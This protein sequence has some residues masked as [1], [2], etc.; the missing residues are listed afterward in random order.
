MWSKK[1]FN[2]FAVMPYVLYID[3]DIL[4]ASLDH[5]VIARVDGRQLVRVASAAVAVV[6][7]VA[8]LP[9]GG[10]TATSVSPPAADAIDT[11]L[12]TDTDGDGLTDYQERAV[13]ETAPNQSDTDGDGIPDGAEV[14]CS[15]VYPDADPLRQDI[16]V[17]VDASD[18]LTLANDT[19]AEITRTFD[20]APVSNP[21]GPDGIDLH[22]V[23]N[24][25]DLAADGAVDSTVRDG[26]H[27]DIHDYYDDHFDRRDAGY[28][29]VVVTSE[30]AFE[31]DS[32]Y[33]GTGEPG[34]AAI[35]PLA[36]TELTA[37]LFMH[38]M[39]HSFGI[40]PDLDGVDANRYDADEYESVMNYN[41]LYERL[42]YSDGTDEVGRDEWAHV[43][44][45]RYQPSVDCPDDDCATGCPAV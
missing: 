43:G 14:R 37:S 32:Y 44:D 16:Y 34:M 11:P 39:G 31:G 10:V 19:V 26:D 28:Y 24:D 33:V 35:E 13:Y 12:T 40:G 45:D 27:N 5:S 4:E 22:I 41:A 23:P 17:E 9:A 29:Y 8:L 30:V 38:E 21:H 42:G 15:A 36:E 20:S 7:V 1:L 25:T 2:W 6:V 18:N 3:T